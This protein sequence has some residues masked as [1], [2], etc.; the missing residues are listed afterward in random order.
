MQH[1]TLCRSKYPFLS[2]RQG[3]LLIEGCS[4][5]ELVEEYGSPLYVYSKKQ[6]LSNADALLEAYSDDNVKSKFLYAVKVNPNPAVVSLLANKGIGAD[7]SCEIEALIALNAGVEKENILLSMA[8]PSSESI[9]WGVNLGVRLNLG[10]ANSLDFLRHLNKIPAFLS[11]RLNPG[12]LIETEVPVRLG[13]TNSKFGMSMDEIDVCYGLAA[14]MGVQDFGIHMMIGSNVLDPCFF[15][16]TA[17]HLCKAAYVI[18]ETLGIRFS[19]INFGGSFGIPYRP[20]EKPLDVNLVAKIVTKA[21]KDAWGTNDLPTIVH[22]PGRYLVGNAGVLLTRVNNYKLLNER[23]YLGVDAGMNTLL[24]PA[25]YNGWHLILPVK[26]SFVRKSRKW[27]IVGPICEDVDVIGRER[28]LPAD[29]S[30]G[31]LLAIMDCGAYGYVHASHYN[32]RCLPAEILVDNGLST[33]IRRRQDK[34]NF[35]D[36]LSL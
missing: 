27:E 17:N 24:R 18:Q 32:T 7:C 21:L 20:D 34:K 23:N 35:I 13:G 36:P 22:E 16:I 31:D 33:L 11:F 15:S 5:C 10:E 29:I 3:E 14:A 30:Y 8:Y 28:Y 25:M 19:A 26:S 1:E 6:I 4:S 9:E 2:F 12:D